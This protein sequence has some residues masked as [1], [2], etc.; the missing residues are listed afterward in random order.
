MFHSPLILSQLEEPHVG[1]LSCGNRFCNLCFNVLFPVSA[2]GFPSQCCRN[3]HCLYLIHASK[4]ALCCSPACATEPAPEP[5]PTSIQEQQTS[6]VTASHCGGE[7]VWQNVYSRHTVCVEGW[8][9]VFF[10]VLGTRHVLGAA[11]SPGE[12]SLVS[13]D[14]LGEETSWLHVLVSLSVKRG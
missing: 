4:R 10:I 9:Q 14:S 2:V 11:P 1:G 3:N 5:A 8:R 13:G 6:A 7:V 12:W